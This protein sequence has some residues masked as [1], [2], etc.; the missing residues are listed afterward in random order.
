[1][2]GPKRI[3]RN[4]HEAI[5]DKL[6]DQHERQ[7]GGAVIITGIHEDHGRVTLRRMA[8]VFTIEADNL[9]SVRPWGMATE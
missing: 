6:I 1:M 7:D 9:E 4:E 8:G 2:Q 3:N 5:R